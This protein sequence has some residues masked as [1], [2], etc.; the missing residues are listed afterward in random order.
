MLFVQDSQAIVSPR[1]AE[2]VKVQ[3][4]QILNAGHYVGLVIDNQNRME[5]RHKKSLGDYVIRG[6]RAAC[7]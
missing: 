6:K 2:D 3:A 4:Q 5:G 7:R 1:G